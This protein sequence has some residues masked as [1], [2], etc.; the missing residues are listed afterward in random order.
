CSVHVL[1]NIHHP[2]AVAARY[3]GVIRQIMTH[4][5]YMLRYLAGPAARVQAMRA[6]INDGSVPQENLA[7]A[8]VE[9]QSGALAHLQASFAADDHAGDPWTCLVKVIGTAGASRYS[10]R[11]WVENRPGS[12][13][14]HTFSAYRESIA[15]TVHHFLDDCVR[16]GRPPLSSLED[17]A[18]CQRLIEACEQSIAEQRTIDLTTA[19]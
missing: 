9:L 4:H 19:P 1:Y 15:A 8:T 10:Y 17:A 18:A 7:M 6:T 14:S 12:V 3:P 16:H 5:A 2:E 11:D 13:H